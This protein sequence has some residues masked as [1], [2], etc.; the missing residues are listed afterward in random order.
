MM[1]IDI[2]TTVLYRYII[3][4]IIKVSI[5]KVHKDIYTNHC[6]ERIIK[7]TNNIDVEK[8]GFWEGE[9]LKK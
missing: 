5:N 7:N 8:T 1:K 4:K 2:D 3:V 6:Y 9:I